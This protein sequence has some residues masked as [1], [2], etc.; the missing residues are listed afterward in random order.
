MKQEEKD[1]W[2]N[3]IRESL[4]DYSVPPKFDGWEKLEKRIPPTPIASAPPKRSF[5][6]YATAAAAILLLI[7]SGA[8]IF[9]LQDPAAKYIETANLPIEVEQLSNKQPLKDIIRPVIKDN[10][11]ILSNSD[12]GVKIARNKI[13][14]HIANA[15]NTAGNNAATNRKIDSSDLISQAEVTTLREEEKAKVKKSEEKKSNGDAA[16]KSNENASQQQK[17][18]KSQQ[19]NLR[20]VS[21]QAES[22][23]DIRDI[24]RKKSSKGWSVGFSAGNS[25]G[26]STDGNEYSDI[27]FSPSNVSFYSLIYDKIDA[28][29]LYSEA[30]PQNFNHKLPISFGLSVRK[31][32]SKRF[33]LESGITYT[34]L[35][36]ESLNNNYASYKQTL[37]YIGIPIKANYL[38]LDRRFVTLYITAGGM[39][40]KSVSG[41]VRIEERVSGN[42][43]ND[44]STS[45]NVKPLQWSIS[46]ALGAQFNVTKQFGIFAEPG[47]IYY[48]NDG[49]KIETIRKETPFNIN[50]QL[51]LRVTY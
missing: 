30:T 42:K 28:N 4:E 17:E 9:L 21:K 34:R 3:T 41:N 26:I 39:A 35:E 25:T 7:V 48:F 23:T 20:R 27:A 51:G 19:Q 1:K 5:F 18:K 14:D 22:V 43:I 6:M 13:Q 50:L 10:T 15:K 37:N 11:S 45:L 33:A 16:V 47:V 8:I 44:T 38:F 29:I 31:Q 32:L 2:V 36:S 24:R 40:E 46:G 12:K 49:S